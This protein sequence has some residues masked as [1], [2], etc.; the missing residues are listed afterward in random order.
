MI[1]IEMLHKRISASSK[2]TIAL[3]ISALATAIL[4]ICLAASNM[5]FDRQVIS[6]LLEF[7]TGIQPSQVVQSSGA[8]FAEYFVFLLVAA[9]STWSGYKLQSKVR[10][11]VSFQLLVLSSLSLW[12]LWSYFHYLGHPLEICLVTAL[13][14]IGGWITCQ[15]DRQLR[16]A[17]AQNFELQ[18]RNRELVEA[19]LQMVKQDEIERR[20]LAADLHDQVLNDLKAIRNTLNDYFEKPDPAVASSIDKSL[21]RNDDGN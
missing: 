1:N 15:I 21:E 11:I 20:L 8:A 19:K 3:F 2:I 6:W 9:V 18:L 13:G 10:I 5:P 4:A 12:G 14:Q 17:E 16:K 7:M